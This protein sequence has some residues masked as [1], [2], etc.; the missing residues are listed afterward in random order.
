MVIRLNIW[1]RLPIISHI[2]PFIGHVGIGTSSGEIHDFAGHKR[3]NKGHMAFGKPY[4]YLLLPPKNSFE[5][6]QWD[7][8]IFEADKVFKQR[9][10]KFCKNNCGHHVS[11]VLNRLNYNG[12][13]NYTDTKILLMMACRGRYVSWVYLIKMYLPLLIII[14]GILVLIALALYGNKK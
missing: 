9:Y 7:K 12:K 14:L 10:H 8:C 13:N 2:F 5:A 1:T 6:E 11:E 4:K 3:I